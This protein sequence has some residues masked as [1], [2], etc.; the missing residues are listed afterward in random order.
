MKSGVRWDG[1]G[2]GREVHATG[3]GA[4]PF[5]RPALQDPIVRLRTGS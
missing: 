5:A 4:V 1:A 2:G 3:V